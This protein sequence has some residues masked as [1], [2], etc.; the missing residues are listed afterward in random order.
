MKKKLSP[1][2]SPKMILDPP[3][4]FFEGG[5]SIKARPRD[6]KNYSLKILSGGKKTLMALWDFYATEWYN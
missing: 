6:K 3:D 2:G 5:I 1:G 4:K